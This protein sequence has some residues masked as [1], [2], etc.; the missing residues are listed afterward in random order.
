LGSTGAVEE[1][2]GA[3][4]CQR[5]LECARGVEVPSHAQGTDEEKCR[6]FVRV[7]NVLKRRIELFASL[8][9]EKLD[10]LSLQRKD[11]DIGKQ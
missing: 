1:K 6:E 9:L 8:P 11:K 10:R 4:V 3:Q 5:G 2:A 7:A